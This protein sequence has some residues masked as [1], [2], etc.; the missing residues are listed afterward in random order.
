MS[1][2]S[3]KVIEPT[4]LSMKDIR[5]K[6]PSLMCSTERKLSNKS[7]IMESGHDESQ[8]SDQRQSKG[9]WTSAEHQSFLDSLRAFGKDWYRVEEAIGTRSS[10]Q[11]RSHAQK[12]LC[13]LE[14]EPD[15]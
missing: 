6:A 12:F 10:A 14:K 5:S 8:P 4:D 7:V 15:E 9:R 11:I 1:N 2:S 3:R 13:K